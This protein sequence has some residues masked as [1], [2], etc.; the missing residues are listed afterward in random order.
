MKVISYNLRSSRFIWWDVDV[1]GVQFHG[2]VYSRTSYKAEVLGRLVKWAI[3]GGKIVEVEEGDYT[4]EI[5]VE[6]DEQKANVLES[7]ISLP[8]TKIKF[9]QEAC[10]M[11]ERGCSVERML[12]AM[13]PDLLSERL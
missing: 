4:Y 5:Q 11:L 2:P 6:I 3:A 1:D 10:M 7:F 12:D 13:L 9:W 8:A